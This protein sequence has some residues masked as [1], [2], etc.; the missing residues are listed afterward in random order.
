ML[1]RWM[2]SRTPVVP[3][4][5]L[6]GAIGISSPV[7]PGMTHATVSKQIDTAF[8]MKAAKAVAI[9]INSPG[10]SAV[11]SHLIHQR[12]RSLAAEKKKK[13][14]IF[15]EDAAASGGYMI[16]CA[17]DE[18]IADEASIV[19]SI[20]VVSASFGFQELL[21]KIG[22]ERRVHTAGASKSMLDPFRPE[23]PEDVQR[24]KALQEEIHEH[25]IALVKASRGD[26]LKGQEKDLFSGEFW[27]G[28]KALELGLV[29]E[30]GNLRDFLRKRYGK[31]VRTP[32]IAAPTS[33]LRRLRGAS[34]GLPDAAWA[35]S[36]IS[37]LE[38]RSLWSRY[39]L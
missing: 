36:L 11:Q 37:T 18:I 20:G 10:G 9:I 34:T 12:I 7:M 28:K 31:K 25:F 38:A 22:V 16:A 8:G 1:P 24:L 19:G 3:V 35:D 5:R 32:L 2:R 33:L 26:K 14:F 13:V 6:F 21:E 17:G 4:V 27:S 30:I 39:G 15:V 29:D 23:K